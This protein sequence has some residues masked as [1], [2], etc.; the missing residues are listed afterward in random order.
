[1][2]KEYNRTHKVAREIH[3][4][5]SCIL[6][7]VVQDP[8]IGIVTITEV[9]MSRDLC[10]AKIFVTFLNYKKQK[11]IKIAIK[12]LQ[13]MSGLIRFLILKYIN[14][15]FVPKLIFMYD[16]SLL[17]GIKIFKLVDKSCK[18]K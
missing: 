15:R 6:Q 14:L 5:V 16:Y 11:E 17:N 7:R 3:R 10:Y 2:F 1:M 13:N 18:N 9:N 8:R 12:L 4:N